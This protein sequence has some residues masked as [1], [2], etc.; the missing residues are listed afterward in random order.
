MSKTKLLRSRR[1]TAEDDLVVNSPTRRNA[2]N[3]NENMALNNLAS[4]SLVMTCEVTEI[5][6]AK[7]GTV[8][9][10]LTSGV[11]DLAKPDSAVDT[12]KLLPGSSH[13]CILQ[14]YLIAEIYVEI[15]AG[16]RFWAFR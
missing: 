15:V 9:G 3:A 11:F 6:L 4:N 7:I 8:M 14:T 13:P 16:L 1:E 5:I 10:S 2:K 12:M